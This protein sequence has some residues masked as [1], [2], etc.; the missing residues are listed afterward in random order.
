MD[1]V[2]LNGLG[3]RGSEMAGNI[4]QAAYA[5]VVYDTRP[6]AVGI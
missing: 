5:L 4:Q 1:T 3:N 6:E 2:G